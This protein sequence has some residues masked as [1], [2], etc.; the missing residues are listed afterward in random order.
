M[1]VCKNILVCIP[2]NTQHYWFV[3]YPLFVLRAGGN[4]GRGKLRIGEI[5]AGGNQ[6][7]GN[8]GR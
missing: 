1:N 8:Q 6:G 4:Q 7:W 5:K 3:Y 2:L